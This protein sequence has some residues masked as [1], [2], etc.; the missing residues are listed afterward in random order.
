MSLDPVYCADGCGR[1]AERQRP[2]GMWPQGDLVAGEEV[3]SYELVCLEHERTD[4]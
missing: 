2:M 1:L 4:G 3:H